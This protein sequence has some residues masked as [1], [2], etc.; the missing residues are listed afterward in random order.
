MRANGMIFTPVAKTIMILDSLDLTQYITTIGY[1]G[2]FIWFFIDQLTPI[3]EEISLITIGYMSTQHII[4]PFLGGLVAVL[5]MLS[6]DMAYYLLCR[7]GSRLIEKYKKGKSHSVLS[8]YEDKMRDKMAKTII[9]LCF[10]PRVRFVIPII[11]GLLRLSFKKFIFYNTLGLSLM[12][13]VYISLGIIFHESIQTLMSKVKGSQNIIFF[14][15]V[16]VL[17]IGA[18]IYAIVK[19]RAHKL[20][21]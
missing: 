5:S 4:D 17:V 12:V 8:R 21:H 10:I 9:V 7:S 2:I 18:V 11:V 1:A 6:V 20:A 19:K 14:S 15:F 13:A 16:G 3:P